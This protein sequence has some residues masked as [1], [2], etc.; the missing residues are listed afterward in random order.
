M[1]KVSTLTNWHVDTLTSCHV[2]TLTYL[3]IDS[4]IP[5]HMTLCFPHCPVDLMVHWHHWYTIMDIFNSRE[6]NVKT[7]GTV[8]IGHGRWDRTWTKEGTQAV[9]FQEIL[10]PQTG[11][12]K[13]S[14]AYLFPD[15]SF[16]GMF[17]FQAWSYLRIPGNS[18]QE[19]L[20]VRGSDPT[21]FWL[22]RRC[23]TSIS[24]ILMD[25]NTF[26]CLFVKNNILI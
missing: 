25:G 10:V 11:I 6:N 20:P 3:N 2:G 23:F 16:S 26:I 13:N 4:L 5:W 12:F 15:R 24:P 9:I 22:L 8:E 21:S 18:K 7:Y 1:K 14:L 19:K 17:P